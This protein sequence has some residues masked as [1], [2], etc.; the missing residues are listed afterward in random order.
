MT[1]SDNKNAVMFRPLEEMTSLRRRLDD[2]Q[3]QASKNWKVME[4]LSAEN[5]LYRNLLGSLAERF[6]LKDE[7]LCFILCSKKYASDLSKTVDE[8][9][10]NVEENLVS[11]ES[12]K[13]G[14]QQEMRILQSGQAEKAEEILVIDGQQRTFITIRAP[15]TNGNGCVSGIF[16]VTVDIGIRRGNHDA[17]RDQCEAD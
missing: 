1:P 11:A 7:R 12:A 13:I 10:G 6:F 5:R 8:V 3:D 14:R 16:G 9:I 17:S 2:I 4:T 15:L